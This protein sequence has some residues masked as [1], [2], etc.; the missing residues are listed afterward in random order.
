MS[1]ALFLQR[2]NSPRKLK[3]LQEI[4]RSIFFSK[5][6]FSRK[7]QYY[8]VNIFTRLFLPKFNSPKIIEFL[9][10]PNSKL[11]FNIMQCFLSYFKFSVLITE[12]ANSNSL[13]QDLNSLKNKIS[14]G[15]AQF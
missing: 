10:K 11:S 3:I 15:N 9:Q 7:Y 4:F 14:N 2:F 5:I 13:Y 12:R 8:T 1:L 6:L